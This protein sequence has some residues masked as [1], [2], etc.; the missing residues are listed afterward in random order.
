M[1]AIPMD[2]TNLVIHVLF[3]KVILLPAKYP[4]LFENAF[5]LLNYYRYYV[6]IHFVATALESCFTG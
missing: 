4:D 3:V 5:F 6:A 2:L 1:I